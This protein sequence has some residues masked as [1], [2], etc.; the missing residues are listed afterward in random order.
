MSFRLNTPYL[1]LILAIALVACGPSPDAIGQKVLDSMRES[2]ELRQAG[3][4]VT[5]VIVIKESG[6]KYQGIATVHYKDIERQVSVQVVTDGEGVMWKV[7]PGAFM[8]I[9]Q[10]ELQR[11]FG[12]SR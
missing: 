1:A 12:Q 6:N 5:K 4:S 10:H 8:F 3:V 9:M 2:T 7:E 11:A